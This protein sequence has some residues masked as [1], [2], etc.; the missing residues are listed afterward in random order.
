M[1]L[2]LAF[3]TVLVVALPSFAADR[4]LPLKQSTLRLPKEQIFVQKYFIDRAKRLND[5]GRCVV[6]GGYDRLQN[7]YYYR[8]NDTDN[9]DETTVLKY[10]FRE[11]SNRRINMQ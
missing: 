6:G 10:T 8:V 3:A 2:L 5:S 4:C 7:I 1:K 9:P 11:L